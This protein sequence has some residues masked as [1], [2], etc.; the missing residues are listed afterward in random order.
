MYLVQLT[1]SILNANDNSPHAAKRFE[2]LPIIKRF[3]LDPEARGNITQYYALKNA[4]DQ[5][6]TTLNFLEKAGDPDAYA[7]YFEENAGLLANKNYVQSVEK[8]M[9]RFR[10]MRSMIQAA[11]MSAEEKR[12]L[13]IDIG[14]AE[15]AMTENIKEVKKVISEVQ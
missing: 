2:Q 9:K 8:Q 14:R 7:K 10:E 4:T 12:D 5:A 1:D 13:L 3:A 11:D 6:V 15:N